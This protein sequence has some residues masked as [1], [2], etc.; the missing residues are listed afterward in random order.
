MNPALFWLRSCHAIHKFEEAVKFKRE[1]II[2]LLMLKNE[3]LAG[4]QMGTWTFFQSVNVTHMIPTSCR[5]PV[6]Y[7]KGSRNYSC[8]IGL[9][10]T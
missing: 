6:C 4:W 8:F 9:A 7:C 10:M 1:Q 2:H 3:D 5:S